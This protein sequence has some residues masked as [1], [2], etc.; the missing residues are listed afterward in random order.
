[1]KKI[2]RPRS[3]VKRR[4]TLK[5]ILGVGLALP[6]YRQA[7]SNEE[8]MNAPPQEDDVFVFAFGEREG[9]IITP[10]DLPTG[11][12]QVFAYPMD[13]AT[14]IVRSG[15]RINQLLLVR[16]DPEQLSEPTRALSAAGVVAY[17]ALCTHTGCDVADW[18]AE[19]LRFQCP[20]HDSQFD[21]ADGARVVGGPAPRPLP[22]LPLKLENGT[23]AVAG[24]FD[25]PVGFQQPGLDPF[26]F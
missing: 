7:R 13:P 8:A 20:C 21:P 4:D 6:F 18:D 25:A 19:T 17:S 16:I 9:E 15:S 14:A 5:A 11:A 10:D 12:G 22:S 26:G 24:G 1:M 23:L 3:T 2:D